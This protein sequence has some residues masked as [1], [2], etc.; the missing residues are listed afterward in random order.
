MKKKRQAAEDEDHEHRA[1]G[2]TAVHP[3]VRKFIAVVSKSLKDAG[4]SYAEQKRIW[5]SIGYVISE[6]T[7]SYAESQSSC[8]R[9]P[10]LR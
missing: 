1:Y 6:R 2:A 9:P 7:L 8:G 3:E 5:D 4:V 10:S